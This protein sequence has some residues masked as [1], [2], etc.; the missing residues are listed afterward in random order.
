MTILI[1]I[2]I[3]AVLL[4]FVWQTQPKVVSPHNPLEIYAATGVD[5]LYSPFFLH[6]DPMER[7]LLINFEQDPDEVYIGFE[8]QLFDDAVHGQG[9]LVIGWRVDGRVDVYHQP[10]LNLD[11]SAY[12]IAGKGLAEMVERPLTD[13]YFVVN[14]TGVD[15]YFAFDDLLGRPIEVTIQERNSRPRKPFGLL[16]P[17]G[18]AA[19]SPSALPLVILHDF[20]FV[21]R[22]ATTI[23]IVV[24]GRPRQPD[25]L[26]LP[27]DGTR[28]YFTRYSPD[29]LIATLNPAHDGLLTPLERTGEREAR[30]GNL[31]FDLI[32]NQGQ[33]EISQMRH[34][35]KEREIVVMFNPPLPQLLNLAAGA[36]TSGSFTIS[37]AESV[38]IVTGEYQ[39]NRERDRAEARLTPSGGW[40]PNESKWTVRFLYWAAST[41]KQWPKT[42]LWTASLDL[43]DPQQVTMQ[44]AWQRTE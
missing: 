29:P 17:M 38:G 28:M 1:V 8:P 22:A 15:A 18:S 36:K 16:A 10:G 11:P 43:S 4:F 32:D 14:S 9:M 41:F 27:L 20:Y 5:L 37:G 19:T 23:S 31:I 2:L 42:Y 3:A 34:A 25:N 6:I 33:T 35:F 30:I 26:P 7:L 24:D 13:A 21:R 44:S 12:D 40:Q 39:I